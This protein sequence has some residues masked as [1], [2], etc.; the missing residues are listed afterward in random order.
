MLTMTSKTAAVLVIL[1][2]I[3]LDSEIFSLLM[4]L[5]GT[6]WGLAAILK[7]AEGRL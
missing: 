4:L 2:M 6:C 3:L 5:A 1:V 7:E